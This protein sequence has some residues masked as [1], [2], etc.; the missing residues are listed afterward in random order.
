MLISIVGLNKPFNSVLLKVP[1]GNSSLDGVPAKFIFIGAFTR[2]VSWCA[3]TVS[4]CADSTGVFPLCAIVSVAPNRLDRHPVLLSSH[5]PSLE[6]CCVPKGRFSE[7]I[8]VVPIYSCTRPSYEGEFRLK[9]NPFRRVSVAL[10]FLC[11]ERFTRVPFQCA[12]LPVALTFQ[13]N[14]CFTRVILPCTAVL[15]YFS[16]VWYVQRVIIHLMMLPFWLAYTS[17]VIPQALAAI[18]LYL[19]GKTHPYVHFSGA[20]RSV[21]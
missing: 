19:K 14:T 3:T 1:S 6:K 12:Q 11:A 9:L 7:Y 18:V 21:I 4:W 20:S 13:P 16:G 17:T 5:F 8:S 15:L 10:T 2:Y